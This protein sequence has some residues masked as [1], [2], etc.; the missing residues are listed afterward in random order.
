MSQ[1]VQSSSGQSQPVLGTAKRLVISLPAFLK[2]SADSSSLGFHI[3]CSMKQIL[4]D[5]SGPGIREAHLDHLKGQ[6]NANNINI[7]FP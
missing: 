7:A 6:E 3:V 4:R 5:F 1:G 2:P